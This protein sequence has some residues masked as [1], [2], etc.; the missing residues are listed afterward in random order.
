MVSMTFG[1]AAHKLFDVVSVWVKSVLFVQMSMMIPMS[2]M[3]MRKRMLGGGDGG[4]RRPV[5]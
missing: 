3:L 4:Y 2:K 1:H 5:P